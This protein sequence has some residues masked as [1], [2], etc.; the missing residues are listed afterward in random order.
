M[1][2]EGSIVA[3]KSHISSF[4]PKKIL[5]KIFRT[6]PTENHNEWSLKVSHSHFSIQL[7]P[8][9]ELIEFLKLFSVSL[10]IHLEEFQFEV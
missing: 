8:S 9:S 6:L 3:I 2:F 7:V 5:K 10:S 1:D 4:T